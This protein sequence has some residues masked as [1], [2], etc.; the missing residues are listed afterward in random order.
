MTDINLNS[1]AY[2]STFVEV[3]SRPENLAIWHF[4]QQGGPSCNLSDCTDLLSI[5]CHLTGCSSDLPVQGDA[6]VS[7]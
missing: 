6:G 2:V 4:P 3:F 7:V 1:K 5:L